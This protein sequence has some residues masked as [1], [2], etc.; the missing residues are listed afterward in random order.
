MSSISTPLTDDHAARGA[1][2]VDFAGYQM[3]LNY[4][5]ILDEVR[6]V[7]NAAGLF[8]LCH[9]GRIRISGQQHREM[10]RSV[11]TC[12]VDDL[13][14]GRIRYALVTRDDGTIIDDVLVYGETD[15]IFVCC[16]AANRQRVMTWFLA[17][18]AGLDAEVADLTGQLG[19]IAIQ[20]PESASV[21]R[22]V[23]CFDPVGLRYYSFVETSLLGID[24]VM[25][26]RT[27]YTG[28]TGYELILPAERTREVWTSLLAAGD[29]VAPI[30]LAARDTLRLEAG[31]PLYGH[32]LD[33]QITP[34]EAG[35]MWA[36]RKS[37]GFAGAA[38]IRARQQSGPERR[39]VG[40]VAEGRRIARQGCQVLEAGEALRPIGEV[41]SGTW[42]P[43]LEKSIGTAYVEPDRAEPGTRL[44]VDLRG[45]STCIEIVELPFLG[46]R[47]SG[48][49]N[50][51]TKAGEPARKEREST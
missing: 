23:A 31:M 9:M 28:E 50:R 1:R 13:A 7:R 19:M 49:G 11:L 8:D 43:T 34:V 21:L 30:G 6:R 39:L 10:A 35:L 47:A 51:G 42:S 3:P 40:F 22:S 12:E 45:H 18:S 24:A 48:T 26:S 46:R 2:L 17:H 41:R 14:P 25:L 4:G 20:G 27:G 33:D 32:E 36:V 29:V 5:S 37:D 16:N 38:A 44:A 15:S